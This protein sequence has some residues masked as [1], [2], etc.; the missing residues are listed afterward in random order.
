MLSTTTMGEELRN[1]IDALSLSPRLQRLRERYFKESPQVCA[2]RVRLAMQ[3]WRETAGEDIELRCAKKLEAILEGMPIV[4][5]DGELTAGN[6][7]RFFR[8]CSPFIEWNARFFDKVVDGGKVAFGSPTEMGS[9]SNEDWRICQEAAGF[10]EGS[11]PAEAAGEL[12]KAMWGDWYDDAMAIRANAP[13]YEEL[14]YLPGVPLWD[15]LFN[16]GLSGIIKE[17]EAAI[18]RFRQSD[19]NDPDKLIFWQSVIISCQALVTFAHR[20]ADIARKLAAEE[21]DPARRRELEEMAEAC[22]WVPENPARTFFEA[23][24]CM[25]LVH[26]ALLMENI[27]KG[28]D[29]G[30]MDRLLFPYFQADLEQGRLTVEKAADIVGEFITYLARLE[31]IQ[32]VLRQEVNQNTMLNHITLG[33]TVAGGED[34]ANELSYLILHVLGLLKYAEPHATVRLHKGTPAWFMLKSLE[35]NQKVNGV[36]MYVSDRHIMEVIHQK[37]VPLEEAREFALSG[38]SQPVLPPRGHFNPLQINIAAILDLA[39]HDGVS[40]VSGKQIGIPTGDPRSF[41]TFN[42]LLDAFK[43]QHEFIVRRFLRLQ[44]MMHL[45]ECQHYRMPLRSALD[46]ATIQNGKSHLIGG[47]DY[48][49][50]WYAKDRALVDVGDSLTATKKL[51]FDEKR[52]SMG[53]LLETL[54][55]DFS[56]ERGEAVRRLCLSAPKYGNDNDE[57]DYMLRDIAKFSASVILSEKNCF[58]L[59]YAIQRNG[60]AW[61]YAAGK[62]VGALPNGRKRGAPFADGSLSP[63]NG[64]DKSGPTAV[65]NSAIKADFVEAMVPILNQKFPLTIVRSAEAMQKVAALTRSFIDNGGLH[66]QFNFVDRNVLLD[67]KAHPER[68]KDLV[69]RVAGYSAYFVNLTPEV[70]DEIISR[71]EQCL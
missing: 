41:A 13:R 5:H 6:Q 49:P 54:D 42:E 64:M 56:G 25:R 32:D 18:E 46:G 67:A 60:L 38:C 19:D 8:G 37:G 66:V 61:H 59:P 11:T 15:K 27:R 17:A 31:R 51:V 55:T 62:K 14:S 26:V 35:T 24:Q 70:Q 57:A 40:P 22:D 65:L 2:E 45:V 68:Y 7:S 43:T 53:E 4:I 50:L 21:K 16:V 28:A 3:S 20:H 23:I 1:R 10:F 69:V 44:R 71:T 12:A 52:L 34:G 39:L 58:G 48:Y 30:R 29:L 36:P 47:S 9:V 63:M 33:G